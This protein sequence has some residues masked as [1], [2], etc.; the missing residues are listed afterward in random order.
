MPPPNS[1]AET[2]AIPAAK[3][4]N[5][6]PTAFIFYEFKL[7]SFTKESVIDVIT[8]DIAVP[9]DVIIPCITTPTDVIMPDIPRNIESNNGTKF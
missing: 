5:D 1:A 7:L 4:S 8:T 3:E 6:I 9:M 2:A